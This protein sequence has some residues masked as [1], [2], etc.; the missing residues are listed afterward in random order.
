MLGKE[1]IDTDLAM[2]LFKQKFANHHT[3]VRHSWLVY[4]PDMAIIPA[5]TSALSAVL[6]T[7]GPARSSAV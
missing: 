7:V 5:E 2:C 4:V 1:Q 3:G 6:V